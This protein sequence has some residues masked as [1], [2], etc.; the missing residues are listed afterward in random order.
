VAPAVIHTT[1]STAHLQGKIR[2]WVSW[3]RMFMVVIGKG[4][5]GHAWRATQGT[6]GRHSNTEGSS[7]NV[8]GR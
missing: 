8:V 3:G 1:A 5:W 6:I 2:Q 4:P 7:P